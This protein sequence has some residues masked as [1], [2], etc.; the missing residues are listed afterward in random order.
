MSIRIQ[1]I[2]CTVRDDYASAMTAA[3]MQRT[4][5]SATIGVVG[6]RRHCG[7]QNKILL[8]Q[9]RKPLLSLFATYVRPS[10]LHRCMADC[11]KRLQSNRC[12]QHQSL[13]YDYTF[14]HE[15]AICSTVAVEKYS[16]RFTWRCDAAD[17][18]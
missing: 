10:V 6:I 9:V 11:N 15:H 14:V 12:S 13:A 17:P 1:G 18:S 8:K 4:Y 2:D 16:I 3:S 5:L 7:K